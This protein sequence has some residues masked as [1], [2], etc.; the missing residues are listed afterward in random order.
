VR[1]SFPHFPAE[2]D[3]P[4]D[5]WLEAGMLGFDPLDSTYKTAAA[6]TQVS[7]DE[8]I[9]PGRS[10]SSSLDHRG[11]DRLRLIAVLKGIAS[12]EAIPPV[13]LLT[14]PPEP[15]REWI[16]PGPYRYRVIDGTHR[17]FASLAAGYRYLPA[18][19]C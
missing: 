14:S 3:I 9:P 8:I 19:V 10:L 1:F 13:E 18:R 17:F 4:D 6:S 11:F 7:L 2:F 5:W 16:V 15:E 12:G